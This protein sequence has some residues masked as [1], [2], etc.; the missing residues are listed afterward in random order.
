MVYMDKMTPMDNR[1]VISTEEYYATI[2]EMLMGAIEEES[3]DPIIGTSEPVDHNEEHPGIVFR[4]VS[5]IGFMLQS[6]PHS[7]HGHLVPGQD[8]TI[9]G[10]N[11]TGPCFRTRE[12][13]ICSRT[14][15]LS[16]SYPTHHKA[17][18]TTTTPKIVTTNGNCG[19]GGDNNGELPMIT[20]PCTSYKLK[21]S[22]RLAKSKETILIPH[23]K[24]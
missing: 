10:I 8:V 15:R 4:L 18:T 23:H 17:A 13:W 21:R 11:F 1:S 22:G 2:R 24:T 14:Y 5:D 3:P 20:V 19:G 9:I 7:P 16:V 12:Y 6:S